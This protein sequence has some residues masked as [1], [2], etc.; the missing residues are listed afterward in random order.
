M[1]TICWMLSHS[2]EKL[3]M[4]QSC[5]GVYI[6]KRNILLKFIGLIEAVH[7]GE[8]FSLQTGFYAFH[9]NIC[10]FWSSHFDFGSICT[11]KNVFLHKDEHTHGIAGDFCSD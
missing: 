8:R 2:S 6:E 5:G 11:K 4:Q 10:E 1:C 3:Q 7:D 9:L